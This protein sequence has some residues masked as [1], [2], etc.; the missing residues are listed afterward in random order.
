V[1]SSDLGL[2]ADGVAGKATV[3]EINKPVTARLKSVIVAMER[4]RWLPSERGARHVLV[5]LA[6]FHAQIIDNGQVTFR[7]RSV[8]GKNQSDR[9]SPEFS[10]TM[11]HM[12]INPSWHVPRSIVVK[13]YL[14]Q[15]QNNPNAVSHIRIT[16]RRGRVVNR[17][18]MDFTQFTRS[19]FPFA[20]TQPPSNRN[21]LGLVKFM[22][23]NKHNIYLHDTPSKSL[24]QRTTRA[25][26]HGCIRVYQPLEFA[27]ALLA[28]DSRLD[29]RRVSSGINSGKNQTL[30]LGEHIPVHITYITAWVE[31]GRI[32]YRNDIYGHDRRVAAADRK[33]VV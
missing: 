20:M 13:E 25:F 14:P 16:D 29:A 10:D 2:E 27:D 19:N 8:V 9:R 33:S 6:D 23:P 1:C 28:S 31:D 32:N 3:D 12:I 17:A 5:N 26:S 18:D 4:E 15:L 11:E 22:F 21:A 7:T 24:F 30:P